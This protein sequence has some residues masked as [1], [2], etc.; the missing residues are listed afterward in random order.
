MRILLAQNM[1]HVPAYGGANRSNRIMLERLAARGHDCTVVAPMHITRPEFDQRLAGYGVEPCTDGETLVFEL[2]GVKVRAV[3]AAH[4]LMRE[5]GRSVAETEPDWI[6]VP[7]DDPGALM[8]GAALVAAPDRVVYLA[9]TVQRL[10]FGPASFHPSAAVTRLVRRCAVVVAV[11]RAVQ[12]HLRRWGDLDSELIHPAV[13]GDGPYPVA[14]GDSVTMVNPCAYKGIDI[15]L[16]LADAFPGVPFLAV[17]TWGATEADHTA[18]RQRLN[19]EVMAPED[20]IDRVFAR[21]R[22]LVM[23]SLWDETFGYTALE[24]LLRG[25]PVLAS[26]VGGLPE[27]MLGVPHLLPVIPISRYGD[28]NG[29]PVPRVPSQDLEP[30]RRTL[31]RVLTD[32]AHRDALRRAGR[33]AAGEFVAGLDPDALETLLRRRAPETADVR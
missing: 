15:F 24:A 14:D 16:G 26:N 13:Y 10:P 33:R 23:P 31:H 4:R 25:V 7:S 32:E 21:T 30:W 9:H 12:D 20:D 3:T 28:D 2:N 5:V 6:L 17:P 19:I 1:P 18:L 11:S 29:R 27:A 8:L 22:A